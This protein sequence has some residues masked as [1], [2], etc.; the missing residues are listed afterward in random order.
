MV[1]S[2]WTNINHKAERPECEKVKDSELLIE[3][4]LVASLASK[5]AKK[6]SWEIM[7][8]LPPFLTYKH[9]PAC[10]AHS[11]QNDDT[12]DEAGPTGVMLHGT[13]WIFM[14]ILTFLKIH[15]FRVTFYFPSVFDH[16]IA[17]SQIQEFKLS[18]DCPENNFSSFS[19]HTI[20]IN[21]QSLPV[22]A[23]KF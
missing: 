5:L 14:N 1:E 6:C 22:E 20:T 18:S 9:S 3:L 2:S 10:L 17:P 21:F 19:H 23:S 16:G 7:K 8:N 11:C 13:F 4:L 12:S 15:S